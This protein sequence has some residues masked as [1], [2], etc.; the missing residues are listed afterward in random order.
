M[1]PPNFVRAFAKGTVMSCC[2]F[3]VV[4]VVVFFFFFFFLLLTSPKFSPH[5]G[6]GLGRVFRLKYP[7]VQESIKKL[8]IRNDGHGMS[9]NDPTIKY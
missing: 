9:I 3:V 6:E 7:K 2:F 4:V 5:F 1:L 8:L